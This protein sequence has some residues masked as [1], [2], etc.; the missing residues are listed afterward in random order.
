MSRAKLCGGIIKRTANVQKF[1]QQENFFWTFVFFIF[2]ATHI[3]QHEALEKNI[4]KGLSVSYQS[5]QQKIPRA[6][7]P[8]P[9]FSSERTFLE[10]MKNE[11]RFFRERKF[12]RENFNQKKET[13]FCWCFFNLSL[14]F[15][16]TFSSRQSNF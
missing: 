3:S 16:E 6:Y 9:A 5:E 13:N 7:V 4:R 12:P 15:H 1:S 2:K 14:A 10:G 8:V 11:K